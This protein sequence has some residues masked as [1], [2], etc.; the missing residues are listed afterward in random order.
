MCCANSLPVALFHNDSLLPGQLWILILIQHCS[1][2]LFSFF[3]CFSSW[4]PINLKIVIG[5]FFFFLRRFANS[6]FWIP[7][8]SSISIHDSTTTTSK[9]KRRKLTVCNSQMLLNCILSLKKRCTNCLIVLMIDFGAEW[10]LIIASNALQKYPRIEEPDKESFFTPYTNWIHKI[11]KK[12]TQRKLKTQKT[13][14]K[15]MQ[16]SIYLFLQSSRKNCDNIAILQMFTTYANP[17]R[18]FPVRPFSYFRIVFLSLVVV[19]VKTQK[20]ILCFIIN[21]KIQLI[22]YSKADVPRLIILV[23]KWKKKKRS[24]KPRTHKRRRDEDNKNK[25][26]RIRKKKSTKNHSKTTTKTQRKTNPVR[27]TWNEMK[28]IYYTVY[29]NV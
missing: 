11:K 13:Q 15:R 2:F 19:V 17:K 5:I 25:R 9:K 6:L 4:P 18:S 28:W 26:E 24:K 7:L 23:P 22:Q 3:F 21:R 16:W 29:I 12:F 1:G 10:S 20:L 27:N 14:K 8:Y